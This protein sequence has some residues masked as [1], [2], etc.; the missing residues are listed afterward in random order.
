MALGAVI[1][2]FLTQL[3]LNVHMKTPITI[4][5]FESSNYL[6]TLLD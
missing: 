3:I 4:F 5:R 2:K 6:Q 1:E